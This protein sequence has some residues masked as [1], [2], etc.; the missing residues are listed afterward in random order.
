MATSK[1]AIKNITRD[2]WYEDV[3]AMVTKRKANM[4]HLCFSVEADDFENK[5]TFS[6]Q[7]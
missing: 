1:N 3:Y 5:E 4:I 2:L 7:S 6:R